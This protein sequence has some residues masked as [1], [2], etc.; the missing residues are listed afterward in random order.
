MKNNRIIAG[1]DIGS[2]AVRL[3]LGNIVATEQQEKL[4]IIGAVSSPSEGIS[5]GVINSI[6]DATSAIAACLE[7]AERLLGVN[8]YDIWLGINGPNMKCETSKG[9]VAVS[10]GDGEINADDVNRALE[11]AQALSV[12]QHYDILH[13]LPV[14]FK[15]DS[16]ECV[17]NPLGMV[18]V[19]LEVEALIIQN[20][21]SQ[22]NNLKKSI[23]RAQ[24]NIDDIVFSALAASAVAL[25]SKQKEL[26]VAL[27][28]IGSSTTSLAVFEDGELLHAAVIP[29]G[30]SHITADVA[31]GLR[32]PITLADKV[33]I[34]YGS[35]NASRFNKT[36]EIDI[37]E[38]IREENLADE[39]NIISK[40][41]VAEIIQ[42][43]VEEI[44]EKIDE[45][46]KKIGKSG[47]LPA[48]VVLI[49][50]GAK[51]SDLV[52]TAKKVLRLP[53]SLGGNKHVPTVIDKANDVEYLTA[54]G[55]VVWGDQ[56]LRRSGSDNSNS[57]RN[58]NGLFKKIISILKP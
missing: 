27:V 9:V 26:G 14:E 47:M 7:K 18:G 39:T 49:G 10:R 48:G 52:E 17:K 19:R 31:I 57:A 2:T 55:L 35:A 3:V 20:L 46:F 53:V 25:D 50:G 21:S 38:I 51:L 40:H 32:C 12:P 43:R 29:L 28:N 56:I 41:Y 54:L 8:V 23:Q 24:L 42:A 30:S 45:E 6:E 44:L 13:V 36:D 37:T 34:L 33:K 4:Q 15:V 11:A 1:L 22:I 5:R 16:Q 58:I